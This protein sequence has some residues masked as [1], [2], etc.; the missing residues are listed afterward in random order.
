MLHV[1]E[2]LICTLSEVVHVGV[3][4]VFSAG[5]SDIHPLTRVVQS[6]IHV[7][8]KVTHMISV[9]LSG[10]PSHASAHVGMAFVHVAKVGLLT[11]VESQMACGVFPVIGL[12]IGPA[13]AKFTG[14]ISKAKRD[15][16]I[17]DG[18]ATISRGGVVGKPIASVVSIVGEHLAS[19]VPT[20]GQVALHFILSVV[21]REAL[22]DLS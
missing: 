18:L 7:P 14:L 22:M 8:H 13:D 12:V 16:I 1:P 11:V 2:G 19:Y 20:L 5:T 15:V 21:A 9:V 4:V 3:I 17:L 6:A 10:V